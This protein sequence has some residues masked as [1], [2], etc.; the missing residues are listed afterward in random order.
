MP[1]GAYSRLWNRDMRGTAREARTNS[2]AT[3]SYGLL[4]RM[5]WI[6]SVQTQEAT[7]KTCQEREIMG[8]DGKKEPRAPC[9]Q[10]NLMCVCVC[11]SI[12]KLNQFYKLF[13]QRNQFF[14]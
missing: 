6:S 10:C 5:T 8:I 3:F 14:F 1:P 7:R 9:C 12:R 4:Q 2:L 11:V 13:F